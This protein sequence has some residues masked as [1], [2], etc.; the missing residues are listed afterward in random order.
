MGRRNFAVL[1]KIDLDQPLEFPGDSTFF[2]LLQ[3]GLL[4]ALKE[5]GLLNEVQY[6][7]AAREYGVKC[8]QHRS[9]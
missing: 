2:D 5:A 9:K 6:R 3:N 7:A 1:Q 4:L 8:K